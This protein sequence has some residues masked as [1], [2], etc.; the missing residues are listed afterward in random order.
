MWFWSAGK[1]LTT[2]DVE[3]GHITPAT[4]CT[5][6]LL[7]AE[8]SKI[9][10]AYGKKT[11]GE[12]RVVCNFAPGAPFYIDTKFYCGFISHKGVMED[13]NENITDRKF[14][15]T[16]GISLSPVNFDINETDFASQ[17]ENETRRNHQN[18]SLR[19]SDIDVLGKIYKRKWV[20]H[21]L[22]ETANGTI[23]LVARLVTRYTFGEDGGSQCD[24]NE[25][26]YESGEPGSKCVE[27]GRRFHALCYDFRDPTPGYRLVAVLA[28]V[29]LF[30]LILY[31]LFSGV[32]R[33]TNY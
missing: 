20:R 10:C 6:Q 23:G 3:C 18:D 4:F 1:K 13:F 8:T 5:A 17:N 32:V 22:N 12:V 7:W 15:A 26:I 28:P 30:S 9:G 14:L 21:K 11:D 29:A 2:T 19:Y 33:Q 24:M 16:L 27:R 25:A 31:D